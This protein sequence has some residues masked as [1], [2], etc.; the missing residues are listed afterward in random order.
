MN[1]QKLN[2]GHY[3]VREMISG[4]TIS[5]NFDHK[6]TQKEIKQALY[7]VKI[8]DHTENFYTY[9]NNYVD[10]KS[11]VL[12]QSTIRGYRTL[13]RQ[14]D[15]FGELEFEK[16]TQEDIQKFI[17]KYAINHSPKSTHNLH[18][19]ISSV[20]RLYKPSMVIY[21]TLPKQAKFEPYIPSEKDIQTLLRYCKEHYPDYYI[22][23]QLACY[24]LRRG[25]ICALTDED[26][27][28]NSVIIRKSKIQDENYMW[29][30]KQSPKSKAGFR[31]V[32]V[33]T[34]IIEYIKKNGYAYCGC[35]DNIN[36]R[37][38]D[39]QQQLNIPS[40]SLHK[41]RHYFVCMCHNLNIPDIYIAETVGH[42][43]ISTT[44]NIY[45]HADRTKLFDTQS[46]VSE[47][48]SAIIDGN[49]KPTY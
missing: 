31:K 43:H 38:H 23:L 44:Q 22:P 11:N 9:A 1:I 29:V 12:S 35:P 6:P 15:Y 32:I 41:L 30:I 18:G 7:G 4:K 3:R 46:Q 24:G 26:I 21:T 40:F 39:M 19:F 33:N 48:L 20:F 27:E 17:N 2:N 5:A 36:N 10:S 8:A 14:L 47:H 28:G 49:A 42:E 16:I 34:E 37:L 25:E 45:T 13:I